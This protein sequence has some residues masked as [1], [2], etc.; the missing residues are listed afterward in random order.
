MSKS[1]TAALSFEDYGPKNRI[2][3]QLIKGS[4]KKLIK[5][6]DITKMNSLV[7]MWYLFTKHYK[8]LAFTLSLALNIIYIIKHFGM[9]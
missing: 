1:A 9:I 7:I 6:T 5:T 4:I 3:K 2:E 8:I